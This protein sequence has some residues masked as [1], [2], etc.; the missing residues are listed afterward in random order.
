VWWLYNK[1]QKAQQQGTSYPLNPLIKFSLR[2]PRKKKR[3][4]AMTAGGPQFSE[5][6]QERR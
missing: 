2:N 3:K 5:R 4:N 6:E 1:R